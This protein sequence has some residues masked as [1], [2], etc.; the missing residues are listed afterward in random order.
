[1]KYTCENAETVWKGVILTGKLR[2]STGIFAN[3]EF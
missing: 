2:V 3:F 1:M